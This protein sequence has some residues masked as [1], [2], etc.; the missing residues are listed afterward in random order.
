MFTP[1]YILLCS[2]VRNNTLSIFLLMLILMLLIIIQLLT[3]LLWYTLAY[4][5]AVTLLAHFKRLFLPLRR[6]KFENF[7]DEK[8]VWFISSKSWVHGTDSDLSDKY[9]EK[10]LILVLKSKLIR[11]RFSCAFASEGQGTHFCTKGHLCQNGVVVSA[12]Y[13]TVLTSLP[14]CF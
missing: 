5:I 3:T 4:C 9:L 2:F 10:C 8:H 13:Y 1:P 14:E 6:I 11:T 12:T 7:Y